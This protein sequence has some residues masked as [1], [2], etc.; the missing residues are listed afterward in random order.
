M[1]G[2]IFVYLPILLTPKQSQSPT[3]M[4]DLLMCLNITELQLGTM[5]PI[6]RDRAQKWEIFAWFNKSRNEK[7]FHDETPNLGT[8]YLHMS[9]KVSV[10]WRIR[11]KRT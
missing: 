7:V 2:I 10:E 3:S 9:N 8:Y 1:V 4:L 6:A 5:L 11:Y